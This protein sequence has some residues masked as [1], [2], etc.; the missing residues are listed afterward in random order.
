[1]LTFGGVPLEE[2]LVT[3]TVPE[4]GTITV[5]ARILGGKFGFTSCERCHDCIVWML[6]SGKVHGGLARAGKVRG[7]TPKVCELV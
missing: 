3:E 1:M 7:A 6:C 4:F 2:G 5:T